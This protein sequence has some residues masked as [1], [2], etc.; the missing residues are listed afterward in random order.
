M[1]L[2]AGDDLVIGLLVVEEDLLEDAGVLEMVEGA[3]D[4][5]AA[6]TL[7]EVFDLAD[8]LLGLKKAFFAESHIEDHGAFGG[9]LEFLIVQVTAEDRAERLV[10]ENLTF[11]LGGDSLKAVENLGTLW[12]LWVSIPRRG[13]IAIASALHSME[14]QA[15]MPQRWHSIWASPF[16]R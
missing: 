9:E 16:W 4:R 10:R 11:R 2:P 5:S 14:R 12:H 6:H 3:I 15:R 7:S 1:D 13:M 8:E